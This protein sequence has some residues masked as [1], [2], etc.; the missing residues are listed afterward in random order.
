MLSGQ[1]EATKMKLILV[2]ADMKHGCI[3]PSIKENKLKKNLNIFNIFLWG[4]F[5][6]GQK[7]VL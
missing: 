3:I 1:T 5:R 2:R 4:D 6:P 7:T